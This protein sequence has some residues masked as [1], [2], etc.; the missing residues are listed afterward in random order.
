M[1]SS[2]RRRSGRANV[3]GRKYAERD[4][5]EDDEEMADGVAAWEYEGGIVV[6]DEVEDEGE[7]EEGDSEDVTEEEEEKEEEPEPEEIIREVT[8]K[9]AAKT[10]KPVTALKGGK[11]SVGKGGGK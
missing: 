6:K 7:G 9:P 1:P 8:P 4:D 3:A 11:R 2:E 10:K 5:E